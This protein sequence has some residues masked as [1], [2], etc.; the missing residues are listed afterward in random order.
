M[1]KVISILEIHSE[2]FKGLAEYLESELQKIEFSEHDDHDLLTMVRIKELRLHYIT[3]QLAC[4]E[5]IEIL[6]KGI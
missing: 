6:K 1:K 2:L 4:I 5:S 3:K